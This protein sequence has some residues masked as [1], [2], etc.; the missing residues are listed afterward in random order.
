MLFI[1]DFHTFDLLKP[2]D[3]Q[4]FNVFKDV[5]SVEVSNQVPDR[6]LQIGSCGMGVDIMMENKK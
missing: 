2:F 6:R 5:N 3:L 1:K 4:G